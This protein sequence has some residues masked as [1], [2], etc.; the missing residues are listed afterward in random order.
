MIDETLGAQHRGNWYTP[1][2]Q[3]LIAIMQFGET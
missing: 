3:R 2:D 1:P